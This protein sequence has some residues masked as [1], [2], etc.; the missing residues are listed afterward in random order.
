MPN[1]LM[2]LPPVLPALHATAASYAR[3]GNP[4][5]VWTQLCA[6]VGF[7]DWNVAR[8]ATLEQLGRVL[9]RKARTTGVKLPP[10]VSPDWR[11]TRLRGHEGVFETSC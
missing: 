5:D 11:A 10:C 6:V 3:T 9:P 4:L 7:W 1:R 8:H 2:N